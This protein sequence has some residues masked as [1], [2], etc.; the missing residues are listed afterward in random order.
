MAAVKKTIKNFLRK[1]W[2]KKFLKLYSFLSVIIFIVLL[3]VYGLYHYGKNTQYRHYIKDK[4]KIELS[5]NHYV[6]IWRSTYLAEPSYP[7]ELE[8]KGLKI[9]V[10]G[11]FFCIAKKL[12]LSSKAPF[13]PGT[14][15][16]FTVNGIYTFF[17][18]MTLKIE[19]IP[20]PIQDI[21]LTSI[22]FIS[23]NPHVHDWFEFQNISE[24]TKVELLTEPPLDL[25]YKKE[26]AKIVV[27]AKNGFSQ[28]TNYKYKVIQWEEVAITESEVQALSNYQKTEASFFELVSNPPLLKNKKRVVA[29]GEFF[30]PSSL[31][32]L[33]TQPRDG[34]SNIHVDTPIILKFN[35]E[36]VSEN[37]EDAIKVGTQEES[38]QISIEKTDPA[39]IKILPQGKW[40]YEKVYNVTIT[41]D[42][43]GI[44]G[45]RLIDNKKISFTTIG[46]I[47]ILEVTP[48]NNSKKVS[49]N[50]K[51]KITFDQEVD[52]TSA[53]K[54]FKIY[55]N[56]KGVFLWEENTLVYKPQSLTPQTTYTITIDKD[57]NS[58]YE[59][60]NTSP[61]KWSFTTTNKQTVYIGKSIK[62]KPI[63]AYIFGSGDKTV[64]YTSGSH[65]NETQSIKVLEKWVDYLENHPDVLPKGTRAIIVVVAN[66]DGHLS[67]TRM[68]A[69]GTDL[70][71]NWGT[72]DWR[73]DTWVRSTYYPHGGGLSP[74]SEPE[75]QALKNLIIQY[76]VDTLI[77]YHCCISGV[78]A[79][80]DSPRSN[81]L[82]KIIQQ[83]TGYEDSVWGDDEYLVTGSMTS[84]AAEKLGIPS[85][86]VE[87]K[88]TQ[89][90]Y[91][92]NLE[93]LKAVLNF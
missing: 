27:T 23:K 3:S 50:T 22:P 88:N 5:F 11:E 42:I 37:V 45:S 57:I 49:L 55:P 63:Y 70:N 7:L 25:E 29:E 16:N 58:I 39:T 53:Q 62:G 30:S 86:T 34:E 76:G 73:T 19:E 87:V 18:P 72:N 51:I 40:E 2:V 47:K 10:R 84:W 32:L 64:L 36:I 79:G 24:N 59:L 26:D 43:I 69:N 81:E 91:E 12:T 82:V 75:T 31:E 15:Y 35:K 48:K 67:K 8:C 71:R 68:N 28:K 9:K 44:D 66:P 54:S 61:T 52:H 89:Y 14:K 92:R 38:T 4:S 21:T 56:A 33:K 93:A 41:K 1:E 17:K 13:V 65:G 6:M 85:V 78:F 20:F 90:E 60:P 46:H 74:F 83:K 77:D 80:D